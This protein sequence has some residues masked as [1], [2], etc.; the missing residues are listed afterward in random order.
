MFDQDG[1]SV[2]YQCIYNIDTD[3]RVHTRR[4]VRAQEKKRWW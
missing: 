4:K 2:F 1:R 3:Y